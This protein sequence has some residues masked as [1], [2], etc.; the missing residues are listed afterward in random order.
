MGPLTEFVIFSDLHGH[1]FKY[2]SKRVP[3]WK[4]AHYNTRLLDAVRVLDEIQAYVQVHEIPNVLFA[5]DLFHRRT[6]LDVDA[7]NLI[8]DRIARLGRI[9][10][11]GGGLFMLPGNHDYA[12]RLGKIHVLESL[13][14]LPGVHVLDKIQAVS[15]IVGVSLVAVP[16]TPNLEQ[17]KE[18]LHLAGKLTIPGEANILMAHQGMRGAKVGSDYILVSDQD[19]SVSDVPHDKFTACF[20]GHYHQHQKLFRNGWY[21]GATHEQNWSDVGGKRGF[22][23]VR[24]FQDHVEFDRIETSAPKFILVDGDTQGVTTREQDFVRVLVD[25]AVS[26]SVVR[27][28]STQIPCAELEVVSKVDKTAPRVTLEVSQLDPEAALR[29]WVSANTPPTEDCLDMGLELLKEAS[30]SHL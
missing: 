15:L 17:A 30:R 6:K 11:V 22:L 27:R 3:M 19:V 28:L 12:D 24:V 9:L 26:E 7:Y 25:T 4:G 23:H 2:G 20:F 16:Y 21:V 14:R 13:Q 29:A 1:N 10:P 8:F 18:L 5:G